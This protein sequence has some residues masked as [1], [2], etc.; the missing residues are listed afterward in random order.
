MERFHYFA[1]AGRTMCGLLIG[2][3][4]QGTGDRLDFFLHYSSGDETHCPH[5]VRTM[6]RW[7][8]FN[9]EFRYFDRLR[10]RTLFPE[11]PTP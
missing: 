3:N 2:H 7:V 4:T 11:L 9:A 1:T 10:A 5:C 8:S 6:R